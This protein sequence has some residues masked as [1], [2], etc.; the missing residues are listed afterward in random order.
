MHI[1]DT[2]RHYTQVVSNRFRF[3]ILGVIFG[4]AVTFVISLFLPP[5]Y[6]ASALVKVNSAPTTATTA[7]GNDVFTAQAQAV[8]YAIL[9]T[10]PQVFQEPTNKPPPTTAHALTNQ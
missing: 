1:Q 9:V 6:Q 3:I 8:S 7:S 5:V 4:S 2:L 10:I